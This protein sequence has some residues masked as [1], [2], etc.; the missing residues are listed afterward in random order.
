MWNISDINM[1]II[2]QPG[3]V[4]RSCIAKEKNC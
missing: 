2:P 3:V 1:Q 4:R